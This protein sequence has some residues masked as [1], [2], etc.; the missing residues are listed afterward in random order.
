LAGLTNLAGNSSAWH[1]VRAYSGGRVELTALRNIGSGAEEFLAE[2]TGILIE[3]SGLLTTAHY[4]PMTAQ[5]NGEI[6][7]PQLTE[8]AQVELTLRTGGI[9]PTVQWVRLKSLNLDEV[10]ASFP[11][12]TNLTAGGS[13]ALVGAG[14]L[15]APLLTNIDN[16]S[17]YASGG[18]VLSLPQVVS[19]QRPGGG[20]A[21]WQ[22]SGAGS[23]IVLAGLTNLAGNSSAWHYV[24]A[25]S[26]GRVELT[27]LRNIG[28]GAR[29]SW[30]RARA[31]QLT[32]VV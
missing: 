4:G 28:S 12:L 8:G 5:N 25:Y 14:S 26:G 2:G 18:A 11:A 6:R 22:A 10:S 21:T 31:A 20:G 19:Y 24:R 32:S 15:T 9:V 3:L 13:I 23:R 27:A 17:L 30:L 1:Y 16:V 29:N 7:V